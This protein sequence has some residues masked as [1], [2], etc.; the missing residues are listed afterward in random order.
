MTQT[1][2]IIKLHAPIRPRLSEAD[3][4][5]GGVDWV[6]DLQ[7]FPH[8][9]AGNNQSLRPQRSQAGAGAGPAAAPGGQDGEGPEGP[10]QRAQVRGTGQEGQQEAQSSA[11]PSSPAQAAS[12]APGGASASPGRRNALMQM[13]AAYLSNH[14]HHIK[15]T[16]PEG[17]KI[18]PP[19]LSGEIKVEVL[20][21]NLEGRR[22]LRDSVLYLAYQDEEVHDVTPSAIPGGLYT[23]L[24]LLET[25]QRKW[26]DRI[27]FTLDSRGHL[28]IKNMGQRHML[29]SASAPLM[30]SLGFCTQNSYPGS[31]AMLFHL[32]LPANQTVWGANALDVERDL[33]T[34]YIM[35]DQCLLAPNF[36]VQRPHDEGFAHCRVLATYELNFHA[37]DP[38]CPKVTVFSQAGTPSGFFR[39]TTCPSWIKIAD[40]QRQPLPVGPQ[41]TSSITL[42]LKRA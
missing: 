21:L 23:R 18:Q 17:F 30:R 38:S 6:D 22:N 10:H 24:G 1:E 33:R 37:A 13:T 2:T 40:A 31:M 39:T 20:G 26:P 12:A 16:L 9:S 7:R 29:L 27:A 36:H 8:A 32:P 4:Q 14:A 28:A 35:A 34:G 25:L 15:L 41:T 42:H 19:N 11:P 5:P 3:L